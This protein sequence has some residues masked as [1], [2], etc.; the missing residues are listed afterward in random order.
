MAS[1]EI[2]G[3]DKRYGGVQALKGASLTVVEGEVHGLLGPNGSGK[4]TLN[5]VMTGAV[6]PDR[7]NL[8]I[9][10]VPVTIRGP[11]DAHKHRIVSVYQQLSLVPHL[12]VA[13][14]LVLG[15]ERTRAG[16]LTPAAQRSDVDALMDRLRPVLGS[17]VT[18]SSRVASLQPG[19]RQLLEF[20][21][22]ILR[23]PRFLVLDEATASLYR[24][25]VALLFE[26][27]RELTAQGT[28]VVFVSHRME[29]VM[30]LCQKATVIRN[31]LNVAT[32]DIADTTP[33][34]L[35]RLMVGEI[36]EAAPRTATSVPTT[37]SPVLEVE[38]LTA[39]GVRDISLQV[40]PGEVVGLGGL[41]GQGQSEL[42]LT[43]FGATSAHSGIVRLDG[44][45]VAF[46][47][48]GDAI[49]AGLALVPGDRG[50]EG[51]YSQRS[52]QENIST[53]TL[54]R[55]AW[56]RLVISMKAERAAAQ[57]QVRAMRIKLG[58]LSDAVSS[59]SGG[60]AQKVVIAKWLLA[61][62]RIVLLDDPTKGVDVGAKL[63]IYALIRA[64]TSDG[65]AVI[66]N[67]SDDMEL[68]E[69][70]DRVLVL[71]EGRI[72]QELV[73]EAVTHDG[74]VGAALRV[75][76]TEGEDAR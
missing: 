55:R 42:L 13:E 71:Y 69:L 24:E 9:D 5:K 14:N 59:L 25:Q 66:L 68:T 43:L 23:K 72:V 52:I 16:W 27:V 29:E 31:G 50:T 36:A 70:A 38:S 22:A 20:G 40:R 49:R 62:P 1:L 28:G 53:V 67:S 45:Q 10:G 18:P 4:S 64:L 65:V 60:N 57:S 58:S 44:K 35:V 6:R 26:M 15:T 51:L 46:S 8:R 75:G 73:G 12:T 34:E 48:P 3:V 63:E 37:V 47:H 33:Q 56:A 7:A 41:Q 61:D 17:G 21:K 32:V 2:D 19:T 76:S 39:H 30:A 11:I 54:R 74:L